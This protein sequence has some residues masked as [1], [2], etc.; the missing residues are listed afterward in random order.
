MLRLKLLLVRQN[1]R[2][3]VC[4]QHL[5]QFTSLLPQGRQQAVLDVGCNLFSYGMW[6]R[7]G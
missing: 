2:K 6:H 4:R 1:M 5:L 3:V 7:T